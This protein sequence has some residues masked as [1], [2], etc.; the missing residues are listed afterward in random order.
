MALNPE[1]QEK[2]EEDVE[3]AIEALTLVEASIDAFI[4]EGGLEKVEHILEHVTPV[5]ER[6]LS[7]MWGGAT[8]EQLIIMGQANYLAKAM[9]EHG[10]Y[11]KLSNFELADRAVNI[12]KTIVNLSKK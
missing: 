5:L 7:A 9:I 11:D 1:D 12:A 6:L 2:V 10:D 4:A 8:L 3:E